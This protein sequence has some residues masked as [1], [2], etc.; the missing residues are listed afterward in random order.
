MKTILTLFMLTGLLLV[1]CGADSEQANLRPADT[2]QSQATSA[3]SASANATQANIISFTAKDTNGN[4]KQ[5]SEWLGQRPT[6]INFWGTWC[7]PCR[8]E[9][10]EMVKIYNEYKANGSDIEIVSLA[11]KDTPDKVA[12]FSQRNGMNWVM[13]MGDPNIMAKFGATSAVPTTIFFD[14]NGVE[15]TRFIGARNYAAFKEAFDA[16]I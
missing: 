4:L 15:V 1:S 2:Q 16:I 8:H 7:P 10:P 6:V 12:S 13:L 14:R 9:I 3:G 11:V 5:S